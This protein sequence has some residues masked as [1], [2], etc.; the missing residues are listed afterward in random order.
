MATKKSSGNGVSVASLLRQAGKHAKESVEKVNEVAYH[1]TG[2]EGIDPAERPYHP[3]IFN[4][5]E[6]IESGWG[7]NMKL[8]PVQRF[9][10]K[11]YYFLPLDDQ[12]RNIQITD[13]FNTKVLYRFTEKEYLKFLHNEGR[14][15]IGGQDHE[16]RQLILP[17][18][19]RAGKCVERGTLVCTDRGLFRIEDLEAPPPEDS[20]TPLEIGVAQ[21]AGRRARSTAFYNGGVKPTVKIKSSCGYTITGTGN[22]RVKVMTSE[23]RVDWRYLDAVRPGDM[24]AV[25]RS[26]DLW[27]K[28]PVDL[29]GHIAEG[30]YKDWEPPLTLDERLGNLLGY[31]VGD[32]SWTDDRGIKVTVEHP[33]TWDHLKGLF[34][35]V[36]GEYRVQMDLRTD[37]TGRIEFCSVAARRFFDSIG[38]S[39]SVARDAKHIPWSVLRSPKPVVCAFLRG[40][41]ETDGC[42]EDGGRN[43]TF[44]S[45]S[46]RLAHEVQVLLL[47]LG[48][49][50][51]VRSK[52]NSKTKRSYA[53]LLVRG[54]R[55]RQLFAEHVGFDSAKK[56][57]PM[58]ESLAVAQE[59]KS[60]TENVP[61]QR[62]RLM[63]LLES[64][65][66]RNAALGEPGWG[67]SHLREALGNTIKPS[68]DED[69]TYPRM[70]RLLGAAKENGAGAQEI[71]HFEHLLHLDYFYDP[72]VTV[73]EGE[74]HVYDLTVPDGESFVANG[75]T[76]HNTTLSGLFASYEVYK[77]L[78]LGNPQAY[79]GLPN[80]NRIQIIS[81]ATDKEQAGILFNEVST[82]LARCEYFEPYVANKTLS[83]VQFRTP[84]DIERYGTT[85][86][87]TGG[88]FVSFVG[89]ATVRVTFK[90]CIA[91]GLRGS[92]N[93]L[94]IMDEMAHFKD[95]GNSSAE[96]VYNAVTPSTAAFSPKNQRTGLPIFGPET[97]TEARIICIS[98]PLNRVGMFHKLFQQAMAGGP[99]AHSLLAVQAPTWE[100]N[101]TV[102]AS[103]YRQKY[104]EDP[105]V[106]ATEHGAQFSDRVRGY[107]ERKQDLTDCIDPALRPKDRG[108]PRAPHQM[109]IDIAL[110]GDGSAIAI[111]HVEGDTIVL[112]YHEVWYAGVEWKE[113]NPHLADNYPTPYARRLG[114]VER[115]DF[116]ELGEWISALCKR[117]YITDGIFDRWS[118]LPL[119]QT[120][121]KK[122]LTQFKSEF[123]TR[124][125]SSKMY[126]T[127]KLMMADRKI[128]LYDYPIPDSVHGD[129]GGTG[130]NRKHSPLITEILDLEAEQVSK[131]IVVVQKPDRPGAHDDMSD[132]YV[133]A[134]WLSFQRLETHKVIRGAY[135]AS[136]ANVSSKSVALGAYQMSRARK[137]G[138][139]SE[140]AVPKN[141][142]LKF[143][144]R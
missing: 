47:N 101:P 43:I 44:S 108:A 35:S 119:E 98:S 11:L 104:H 84:Y 63:D 80:G 75:L 55:S 115:L 118:G 116:D 82:H 112:D 114:S 78:N 14:C 41:F 133:R 130:D 40:L 67:R 7:L 34:T 62:A 102:P 76:N 140:R 71:A 131:N 36:F 110:V 25:N 74:H 51:S 59:G 45:A 86:R 120:L 29:W 49:V 142:G 50:S 64:V 93:V 68:C 31:L 13:M 38:W 134:V 107:I 123:F 24:L 70:R 85:N 79:Y 81:V 21:E 99:A 39:V 10:V 91:K 42:A 17:I 90:S 65:P 61:F 12:E 135:A 9:L 111:T 28:E 136:G 117:F 53:N 97:E 144:G 121:H 89:K 23:G 60:D 8:Y 95:Q 96:E 22:H 27:A 113:S 105:T 132:A 30:G 15:N 103:Y 66:K 77:L 72:V 141:M 124:D 1:A 48:I 16:R 83:H 56:R 127:H 19:R 143:R 69:T 138:G 32:G 100:V 128:Q 126:Q 18:G 129:T 58:L 122:G 137:H 106:F 52:W 125:Q 57:V 33:E 4:I 2:M 92:G 54:V 94:V 20:F 26:S 5:M 6:Y 139:F 37:N 46:F 3:K 73:E 109:G 87:S 88:K